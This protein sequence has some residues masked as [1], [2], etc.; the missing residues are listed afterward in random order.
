MNVLLH[1]ESLGDQVSLFLPVLSR[2]L[3][4][5]PGLSSENTDVGLWAS[6]T[7]AE[8]GLGAGGTLATVAICGGPGGKECPL[9]LGKDSEP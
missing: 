1:F 6:L 8:S 2:A 5:W 9:A 4:W 7:S 3:P